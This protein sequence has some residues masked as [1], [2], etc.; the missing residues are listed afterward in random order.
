M[1]WVR[2]I[3]VWL[4]ASLLAA[5][6]GSLVQTQVNLYALQ[7]MGAPI[8]WAE[9]ITTSGQDLLGFAPM[10]LGLVA[11][12]FA[13]ALPVAAWIAHRYGRRLLWFVLA[14]GAAILV[15]LLSMNALLG[16]T[17]IAAS[18]KVP[19]MLLLALSGALGGALAGMYTGR[20]KA[21]RLV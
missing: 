11:I 8:S 10:W 21:S 13:V 7:R 1:R 17:P 20:R 2:P 3:A 18:R 16:I 5:I 14:G 6:V 19:G 15:I 9:R 4:A 12:G